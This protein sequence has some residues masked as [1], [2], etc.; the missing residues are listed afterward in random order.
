M[1]EEN[2]KS[3]FKIKLGIGHVEAPIRVD[4]WKYLLQSLAVNTSNAAQYAGQF[5]NINFPV[6]I[7]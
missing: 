6:E 2:N 7:N 5:L 1:N 3:L 4:I